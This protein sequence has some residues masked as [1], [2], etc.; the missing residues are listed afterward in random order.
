MRV[1]LE[2]GKTEILFQ[3]KIWDYSEEALKTANGRSKTGCLFYI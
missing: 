2:G 3:G 1:M